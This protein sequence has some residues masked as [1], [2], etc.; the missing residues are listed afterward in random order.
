[1]RCGKR[2]RRQHLVPPPRY[3][4][5]DTAGSRSTRDLGVPSR[6]QSLP[7]AGDLAPAVVA[8]LADDPT[9]SS[10]DARRGSHS[11]RVAACRP[12]RRFVVRGRLVAPPAVAAAVVAVGLADVVAYL[13]VRPGCRQSDGCRGFQAS[14]VGPAGRLRHLCRCCPREC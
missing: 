10:P 2:L 6:L 8:A 12:P 11:P 1:V 3:S 14:R 13:A 7:A 4:P 5:E 9:R